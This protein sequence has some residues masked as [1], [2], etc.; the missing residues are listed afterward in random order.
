L[1][2]SDFARSVTAAVTLSDNDLDGIRTI[3][4]R[5]AQNVMTSRR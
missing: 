2:G 4:V 3:R 1:G 5:G